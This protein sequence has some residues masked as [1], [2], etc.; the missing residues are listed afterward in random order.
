MFQER[1][2]SY[3]KIFQE[4]KEEYLQNP[5]AKKL[6]KIQAENEEIEKRIRAKDEEIIAKE[7]ESKALQ[8]IILTRYQEICI[9]C[10]LKSAFV[11]FFSGDHDVC[12]R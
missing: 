11:L 6:L 9:C 7:K 4:R 2:E 3:W 8:G 10:I 5:L 12:D 1:L